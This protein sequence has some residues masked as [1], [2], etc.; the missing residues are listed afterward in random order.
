VPREIALDELLAKQ[1]AIS[2]RAQ[3]LA[4]EK[5]VDKIQRITAELERDARELVELARDF[6]KQELAKAGPPPK[7]KLEV[8]LTKDQ[9]ERIKRITGVDMKSVFIADEAGVLSKAMPHT[10]PRDI[11]E[12]ALAEARKLVGSGD[13]DA[14][15]KA[16]LDRTVEAIEAGGYGE[17]RA[18][19]DRLRADPN[20][21]GGLLHKKPG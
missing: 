10:S 1:R 19:L 12:I 11:E 3:A 21:M 13:A 8:V 9:R 20:W 18:E 4:S 14:I 15:I 16:E 7:G 6:E 2:E 5:D 17:A